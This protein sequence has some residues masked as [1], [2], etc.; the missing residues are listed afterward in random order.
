MYVCMYV[1]MC[2]YIHTY[3]YIQFNSIQFIFSQITKKINIQK[4]HLLDIHAQKVL[5]HEIH[6]LIY[7][8]NCTPLK[9][10]SKGNIS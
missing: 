9:K 7:S 5:I 6:T 3:I 8:Y 10:F 2:I 1:C 4:V